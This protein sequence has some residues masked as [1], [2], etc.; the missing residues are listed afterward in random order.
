MYA[1]TSFSISFNGLAGLN[2][3]MKM[4]T[5]TIKTDPIYKEKQARHKKVTFI[6]FNRSNVLSIFQSRTLDQP[7]KLIY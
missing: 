4:T 2:L 1:L 3:T 5:R 7:I 6:I